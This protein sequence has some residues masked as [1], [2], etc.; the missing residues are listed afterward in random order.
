ME[1]ILKKSKITSSIFNQSLIV[2]KYSDIKD[3]EVLGWCIHK[4]TR[5]IVFYDSSEGLIYRM[6]YH[7]TV[8]M[9][10]DWI[11][12]DNHGR[13]Q[14]FWVVRVSSERLSP[15]V[16]QFTTEQEAKEIVQIYET[17]IKQAKEKGQ[18]YL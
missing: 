3:L 9:S 5:Y 8:S 12:V 14:L 6:M 11:Q 16:Y 7:T 4:S 10:D 17:V 13:R 18:F 1:V 15:N 2:S